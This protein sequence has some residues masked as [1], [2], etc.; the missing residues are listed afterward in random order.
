MEQLRGIKTAFILYQVGTYHFARL[1]ALQKKVDLHVVPLSS[2]S[3]LREWRVE[4]RAE[5][6]PLFADVSKEMKKTVLSALTRRLEEISPDVVVVSGYFYPAMREA[7]RWAKQNGRGTILLSES[8]YFDRKRFFLTE[9]LK[10]AWLRRHFDACFVG[11]AR[12][13]QYHEYL[14][15]PS[16]QIWSGYDVVN[17]DYF[18][19]KADEARSRLS[20]IKKDLH[21]PEKYFLYVGR[22]SPEKNLDR[23]LMSFAKL[24]R[25]PAASGWW[26]VMTGG[27]PLEKK[28]REMCD[29]EQIPNVIWSGFQQLDLLP[30]FYSGASALI[31]PSV[32]EPWG[33]VV[34]E[35]MACSLPVLVSNRCGSA[36][37]LVDQG[38]NGWTFDPYSINDIFFAMKRAVLNEE[39]LPE[40]GKQSLEIIKRYSPQN[41][42]AS[43]AD[44]IETVALKRC[45]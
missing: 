30:A 23:L 35:A 11:G 29:R 19:C 20:E 22:F 32:S 38:V 45:S 7:A 6:K 40:M 17:N 12:S 37:D 33:L 31:L 13:Q 16:H 3:Y 21:L 9:Q 4:S 5:H 28:L 15:F 27:G 10:G 1:E 26:L 44:C 2:R 42:A 41:S 43:L 24:S 25:E 34:N 36:L 8:N 18:Y 14:G 39:Q